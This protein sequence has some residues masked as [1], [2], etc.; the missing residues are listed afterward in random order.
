[1]LKSYFGQNKNNLNTN[2]QTI[3]EQKQNENQLDLNNE[4]ENDIQ[5]NESTIFQI[6]PMI[7]MEMTPYDFVEH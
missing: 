3:N 6:D 1:M 4:K 2:K 5:L 7:N